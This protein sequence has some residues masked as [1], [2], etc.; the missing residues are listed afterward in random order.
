MEPSHPDS[1]VA[2][3]SSPAAAQALLLELIDAG[4][5]HLVLAPIPS[6]PPAPAR[7]L[8]HEIAEPL[9]GRLPGGVRGSGAVGTA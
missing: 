8:A 4:A 3:P 9:P 1:R 7:W 5:R 6:W 2:D